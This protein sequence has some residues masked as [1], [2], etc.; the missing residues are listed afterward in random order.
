MVVTDPQH[1]KIE[2]LMMRNGSIALTGGQVF[3]LAKEGEIFESILIEDGRVSCLGNSGEVK[4]LCREKGI[5]EIAL[6]G[7]TVLPGPID[8]HFHL[9]MTGL[10]M[11][12][13]DLNSCCS[14]NEVL[15]VLRGSVLTAEPERWILGKGLD[16]FRLKERRPPTAQELDVVAQKNP[17]FIEDRGIHYCVLNS[18][19]VQ[20]LKMRQQT[21]GIRGHEEDSTVTGRYLEQLAGEVRHRLLRQLDD[22]FK[23]AVIFEA[24]GYAASCGITT[25]HA[26]EGGELYGDAEIPLLIDIHDELP[27][28][29]S[30]HWNTFK[31]AE[32]VKAGL[33][34]IGGDIWLDGA[35]GSHTAA[36]NRPY[37]DAPDLCGELY[38]ASE[39]L[40]A[41]V[42]E[43]MQFGVQVG[44]HAIG[45]RAIDQALRV[46][47]SVTKHRL[48]PDRLLRLDHFGLPSAE[49][50]KQAAR[51]GVVIS[52][53]PTFPYFRG[54]PGRVY[55]LR[56]GPEREACAYPIR[57]L[58]DSGLLVAGAS[59]SDVLPADIM[60]GVHAA[61]NH[62]HEQHRVSVYEALQLYTANAARMEFEEDVKGTLSLGKVGDTIIVDENPFEVRETA[63]K[64]IRVDMTIVGGQIAYQNQDT[65]SYRS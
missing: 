41:L 22:E 44:F 42:A 61:V 15:E 17:V 40:E 36:L 30:V 2:S 3:T 56:L 28:N 46:F 10:H 4:R 25:L 20:N 48:P 38:H 55:E 9:L 50:L 7:R 45:D 16:E 8:T 34:V 33:R 27:V 12:A 59:D 31:I 49:H 18:L 52:T 5:S 63:I 19:A 53:Q 60:L 23:R 35:L 37:A 64:D 58:F 39:Q 1:T 62:P 65:G 14:V 29:V 26:I 13:V 47:E 24:A 11:S 54:G 32:A 57:A 21:S 43:C 6:A 51:L